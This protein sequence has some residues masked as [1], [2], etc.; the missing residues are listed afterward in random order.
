MIVDTILS[1]K[2]IFAA[3]GAA[4]VITVIV[5]IVRSYNAGGETKSTKGANRIIFLV[6]L[7]L[8]ISNVYVIHTSELVHLPTWHEVC[9]IAFLIMSAVGFL[10]S[11]RHTPSI[12]S[13]FIIISG[14][15]VVAGGI[16]F[17]L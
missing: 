9:L 7:L 6:F 11:M 16:K 12:V 5:S 3:P 1:P 14:I 4:F 17:V 2:L 13:F 10:F 8:A 15:G